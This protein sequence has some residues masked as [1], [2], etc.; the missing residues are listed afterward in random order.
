MKYA[1]AAPMDQTIVYI[2]ISFPDCNSY[3]DTT[4]HKFAKLFDTYE[5]AYIATVVY[6]HTLHHKFRDLWSSYIEE[7]PDE[8]EFRSRED[9]W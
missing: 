7:V 4:S 6:D 1:V 5:D 9:T 8:V 3:A 2:Q